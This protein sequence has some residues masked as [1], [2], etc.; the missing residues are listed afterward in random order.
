MFICLKLWNRENIQ[1]CGRIKLVEKPYTERQPDE[2]GNDRIVWMFLVQP[3]PYNDVKKPS[4]FVFKDM[5]D[6][7][8]RCRNVEKEYKDYLANKGTSIR[9]KKSGNGLKGKKERYKTYGIGTI[10]KFDGTIVTVK[11]SD[12]NKTLNYELCVNKN[13]IAFL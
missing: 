8:E 11:F 12:G 7:K 2:M 4:F 6:Y 1:Y 10:T 9:S 13:I 5:K 3:I